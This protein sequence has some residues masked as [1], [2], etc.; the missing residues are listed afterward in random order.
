[1]L[2]MI[3]L[4]FT[5][6]GSPNEQPSGISEDPVVTKP[7]EFIEDMNGVVIPNY[8]VETAQYDP[9]LFSADE[10]GRMVYADSSITTLTGVDV[11][12]HQKKIDWKKVA[13][14][15]IDFA[16]L[17]AA[18]RGYG[19]KGLLVEDERFKENIKGALAAGLDVGVY[20]FS[21]AV[22]EQEAVEEA[23]FVLDLIKGYELK[24]PVVFDWERYNNEDSRT[25][26]TDSATITACAKAF[27]DRVEAAGYRSM[28]YL[29]LMFGYY[30][31]NLEQLADIDCWLAQYSSA[32]SY[33]YHYRMWQYTCK[34]KVDGIGGNVDVNIC[35]YDY[36]GEEMS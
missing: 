31:Y 22:T 10:N 3:S 14:D 17:R 29:N 27:C 16:I 35:L 34:G 30:E 24:Y 1:M 25:Y 18:Y 5:A 23:E 19:S 21:Q 36:A 9:A 11:S 28:V 20:V 4:L 32:P 26:Y 6:C 33:Y 12:S 15:G 7:P 13:A 8:D 2:L